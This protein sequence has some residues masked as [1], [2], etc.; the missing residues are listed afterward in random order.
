MIES[1]VLASIGRK[2]TIENREALQSII[3]MIG[4]G[5]SATEMANA[6][7][8]NETD[9]RPIVDGRINPN[10]YTIRIG[11]RDFSLFGPTIGLLRA[12]GTLG[13][14]MTR[15]PSRPD[16]AMAAASKALAGGV[17]RLIWDNLTGYGFMGKEAPIGL[18]R[19]DPEKGLLAD[20][21]DILQYVGELAMPIA[22]GA[23]GGELFE[24]VKSAR[25][26]D[27][28]RVA[29]AGLA[30]VGEVAG[31][32]V[33]P[34]SRKDEAEALSQE[35]YGVPYKSLTYQVQD[36]IDDL[37][38]ER[39]GE[40][41]KRGRKGYL[42]EQKDEA[43]AE[44]IEATQKI[45]NT[46][47]LGSPAGTRYHPPSARDALNEA[48]AMHRK[49]VHGDKWSE[50]KGRITGGIHERLYDRDEE[51]EVPDENTREYRIWEYGQT[52]ADATDPETGKLDFDT[53]NKLQGRFW[54]SLGFR[55]D[56]TTGR[57]VNEVDEMLESIRL[58]EGDFNPQVQY[59]VDAGRYAGSLKL[60]LGGEIV[61]YYD[62]EDHKLVE[63]YIVSVTGVRRGAIRAYL[64]KGYEERKAERKSL[65][66]E[67]IGKALDKAVNKNGILWRLRQTFV[68]NAPEEWRLAMFEAGYRY[69]GKPEIE[70]AM[71]ERIRAG[72]SLPRLDFK[73]LYRGTL[74]RQ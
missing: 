7:L 1:D 18:T 54:A 5:V 30:A 14:E 3:R 58:I 9:R 16:K 24:G 70:R 25:E 4:L 60:N 43:N 33:S 2:Q 27:W 45:A 36:E 31:V 57:R 34:M 19:E 10:F 41:G 29:G 8:G 62:L 46:Y 73:R 40:A 23:V 44:L 17:V 26:R 53:L 11:G 20:P 63:D 69:Q 56:P 51:Q 72:A 48:K 68:T 6:M 12:I 13:V 59:L 15:D 38:T 74:I 50:E 66:G 47:L 55:T 39:M 21:M 52:F 32:K 37:V 64:D 22:P 28:G 42:Y 71:F 67:R 35:K 49:T 65:Q 61:G